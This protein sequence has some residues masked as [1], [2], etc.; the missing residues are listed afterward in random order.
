MQIEDSDGEQ[1]DDRMDRDNIANQL[2]DGDEVS[3]FFHIPNDIY[4]YSVYLS[5]M[6]THFYK[7]KNY[8][9]YLLLH[10]ICII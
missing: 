10:F 8:F 2:F 6:L 5:Y 9:Y 3:L 1:E 7:I 4:A